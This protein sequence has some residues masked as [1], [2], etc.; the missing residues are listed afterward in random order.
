MNIKIRN[1]FIE[2]K[3][4]ISDWFIIF[5]TN[6]RMFRVLEVRRY[7]SIHLYVRIQQTW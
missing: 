6:N 3:N 4:S 1:K 7:V 5:I 2:I